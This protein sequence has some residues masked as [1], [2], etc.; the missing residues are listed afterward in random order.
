M[1]KNMCRTILLALLL[2]SVLMPEVAF[3]QRDTYLTSFKA[4]IIN[5]N[6]L[7]EKDAQALAD[8]LDGLLDR[9][10]DM[11]TILANNDTINKDAFI[12][13]LID[14]YFIEDVTT[15][16]VSSLYSPDTTYSIRVY[17]NR[18]ANILENENYDYADY[19]FGSLREVAEVSRRNDNC[20]EF[21]VSLW[22]YFHSEKDE[23]TKYVDATKK[24]FR[25]I[26]LV[27]SRSLRIREIQVE[28]TRRIR[29][30]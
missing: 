29:Y 18:V 22:Q 25:F 20:Y 6:I 15:V 12:D 4:D 11:L 5:N 23:E 14:K 1:D 26:F 28:E 24:T 10:P 21:I 8:Q 27:R 30:Y 9:L 2:T 17:L 16:E 13:L 3:S 19:T 7:S